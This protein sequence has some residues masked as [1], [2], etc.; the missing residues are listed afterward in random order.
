MEKR[1]AQAGARRRCAP[2]PGREKKST[3]RSRFPSGDEYTK[4]DKRAS[5]GERS[6]RPFWGLGKESKR[7]SRGCAR[8][9]GG[10]GGLGAGRVAA[11]ADEIGGPRRAWGE[12]KRGGGVWGTNTHGCVR[13]KT[14][15]YNKNRRKKSCPGAVKDWRPRPSRARHEQKEKRKKRCR[16]CASR[17]VFLCVCARREEE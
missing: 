13:K 3:R 14:H 8:A 6:R 11:T 7:E 2:D 10:G 9:S 1:A 16:V 5:W 12:H 4:T 17:A 15:A